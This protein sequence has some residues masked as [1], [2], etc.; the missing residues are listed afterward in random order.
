MDGLFIWWSEVWQEKKPKKENSALEELLR[1]HRQVIVVKLMEVVQYVLILI[2]IFPP[3]KKDSTLFGRLF[4]LHYL[5]IFKFSSCLFLLHC[6]I[7]DSYLSNRIKFLELVWQLMIDAFRDIYL[8]CK[9]C[10]KSINQML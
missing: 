8:L 6:L 9:W 10:I 1:R 7:I 4:L 2:M 3:K 5:I